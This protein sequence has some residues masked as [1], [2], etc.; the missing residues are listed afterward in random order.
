MHISARNTWP[1]FAKRL[2]ALRAIASEALA[3]ISHSR[4]CELAAA[5]S[6][7]RVGLVGSERIEPSTNG[8]GGGRGHY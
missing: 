7:N 5:I 2:C 3:Q 8:L 6:R 4:D 1:L